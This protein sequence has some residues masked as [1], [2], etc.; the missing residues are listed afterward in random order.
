MSKNNKKWI[1]FIK[2]KKKN[3]EIEK[4]NKQEIKKKKRQE[5]EKKIIEKNKKD[6]IQKN[7]NLD[8]KNDLEKIIST[9]MFFC[10]VINQYINDLSCIYRIYDV[11]LFNNNCSNC[12]HMDKYISILE[13]FLN[14][15]EI[16]E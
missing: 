4:K 11:D 3:Q 16:K 10:T 6:F 2:E 14:G 12:K 13:D 1:D 9:K 5:K 8:M 15:R 7:I